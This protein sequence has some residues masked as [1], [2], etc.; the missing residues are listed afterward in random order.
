MLDTDVNTRLIVLIILMVLGDADLSGQEEVVTPA[1]NVLSVDTVS[2]VPCYWDGFHN[3]ERP[4]C[5]GNA[6]SKL[7]FE[8]P[9]YT[10]F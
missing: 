6:R 10:K 4:L 7:F 5:A 1:G 8:C 3:F 2:F 9:L